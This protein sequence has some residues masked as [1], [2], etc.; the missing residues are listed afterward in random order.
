[1]PRPVQEVGEKLASASQGWFVRELC[2]TPKGF[3]RGSYG[4]C[5][6]HPWDLQ[7]TPMGFA[8]GL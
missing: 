7:G 1:M 8:K 2:G 5:K 4:I 6:G 3:V